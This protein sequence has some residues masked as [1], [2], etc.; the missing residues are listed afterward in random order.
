MNK[1]TRLSKKHSV[2]RKNRLA[3]EQLL[4]QAEEA[5]VKKP[6]PEEV[7]TQAEEEAVSVLPEFDDDV[8][9]A[10]KQD[11]RDLDLGGVLDRIKADVNREFASLKEKKSKIGGLLHEMIYLETPEQIE[12]AKNVKIVQRLMR[13]HPAE[14]VLIKVEL[15]D[16]PEPDAG[17][18][19]MVR[20][21]DFLNFEHFEL[22][23]P[24]GDVYTIP[25]A[26]VREIVGV[27][28]QS[29]PIRFL[30]SLLMEG[31]LGVEPVHPHDST[32]S[33]DT[34]PKEHSSTEQ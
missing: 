32:H 22:S 4:T 24:D 26:S 5:V 1:K 20:A 13:Q 11:N 3:S 28:P 18:A 33:F 16:E 15:Y 30:R 29:A 14:N 23:T 2:H 6:V 31:G 19:G 9:P 8:K 25:K 10:I 34:T 21:E 12:Q 17:T 7:L 27:M